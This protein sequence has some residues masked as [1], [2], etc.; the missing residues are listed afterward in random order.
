[1][2]LRQFVAALGLSVLAAFAQAAPNTAN[3]VFVVDTSGSMGGELAF[4]TQIISDLD[5]GLTNAGVGTTTY[6][7]VSFGGSNFVSGVGSGTP[8]DQTSGLVGVGAAQA[9]LGGLNASGGFEDGYEAIQFARDTYNLDGDAVNFILVTDED[10]DVRSGDTAMSIQQE[11]IADGI[12][13]NAVVNAGLEDGMNNTAIG[14][15]SGGDAYIADGMGGFNTS[16][17]GA[18]TGAAD[19][20]T[21]VDYIDVALATGGAAWDLNQLRAGGLLAE[22]F[23]QAFLDIK[24]Q[25]IVNVP[26]PPPPPP[27]GVPEPG[28]LALLSLGLFG[29]GFASR[30]RRV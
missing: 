11:L 17:G 1:M 2:K 7:V 10:R 15:D 30:R 6:G 27:S 26:P 8:I 4:L 18:P 23:T 14:I 16:A 29:A 28:T 24:I 25:E 20:S 22:S 21:I 5:T 3:V 13:L 9:A 19:G 12:L